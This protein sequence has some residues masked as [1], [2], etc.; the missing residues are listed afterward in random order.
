MNSPHS[1]IKWK[2]KTI[3][4][5]EHTTVNGIGFVMVSV[6]YRG[7]EHR[8]CQPKLVFVSAPLT[9]HIITEKKQRFGRKTNQNTTQYVLDII[10]HK[11]TQ[12]T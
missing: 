9:T 4:L 6:L 11:Q 7:F 1:V 2:T 3:T 12:I 10:I 5:S 8:S